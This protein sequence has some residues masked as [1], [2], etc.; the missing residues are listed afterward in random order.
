MDLRQLELFVALAEELHFH[1]AAERVHIS[2]PAL[3]QHIKRLERKLGVVLFERT[4]RRVEIT[5]AGTELL[6]GARDLLARSR[7]LESKL[8]RRATGLAGTVKMGVGCVGMLTL[9]PRI[10]KAVHDEYPDITLELAERNG[11]DLIQQVREGQVDLALAF[12]PDPL[13]PG[14]EIENLT[15]E[16]VG[17]ALPSGHRLV[18]STVLQLH[19]LSREPFVL[20]PRDFEPTTYDLFFRW[21]SAAGFRPN[22]VQ[23]ADNLETLL[24]LVAAGLGSTVVSESIM[25]RLELE[26]VAFCKL[27]PP[28]PTISTALAFPTDTSSEALR[29]VCQVARELLAPRPAPVLREST[30]ALPLESN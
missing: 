26:G 27:A 22:V 23:Q 20:F 6:A 30:D 12:R 16:S 21:C 17:L 25:S 19:D 13:P 3:S 1:R 14:I 15:E 5:D 2:Q 10:A 28:A 18:E 24:G 4:H 29:A 9:A 11:G 8:R 7:A